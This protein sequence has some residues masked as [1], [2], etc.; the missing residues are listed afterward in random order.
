MGK[1]L[2]KERKYAQIQKPGVEKEY[3]CYLWT[4]SALINLI[5]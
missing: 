4:L 3:M 5:N 1:P 2:P